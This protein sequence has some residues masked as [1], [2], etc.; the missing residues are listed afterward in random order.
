MAN[1]KHEDAVMKMGFDYF[2]N[3]ILKMLGIDYQYE[4]IGPTELVELTIHSLYMDFTFLTTGG[5]Y[6]GKKVITYVIYSGG[7][8]N[9][10]SEL[11]CGLYTYKI[12]PIYLKDKNADE[13]FRK[14]KQ[15]QDNGEAFTEDDYAALSLTP[16]MSGNMSRKDM[17]KEA[18]R[19]TKPNVELSA[20]KATAMLYALADKF[21]SKTELDEI[22]EVMSM[23]RLGQMLM[24]EGMEK[25]IELTQTASIKK[26]MKNMGWTID[27][28][29]EALDIPEEKREKY[30]QEIN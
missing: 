22:K 23:T 18:I 13:V 11:D 3:T 7:I 26:L 25:G 20:D 9:V 12:Q 2:R 28:A 27:Q 10:K 14:L 24:D 1:T 17:F 15:K 5:F 30:R 4:E 8:T 16:L 19:L 6:T 29:M 21:L